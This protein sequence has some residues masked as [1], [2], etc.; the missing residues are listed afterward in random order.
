MANKLYEEE[1]IRGIAEAIRTKN[2]T[3]NTYT[4]AQMADAILN[5][6]DLGDGIVPTGSIEI[7]SNGAHDVTNFASAIVNVETSDGDSLP[8]NVK[9]GVL[10]LESDSTTAITITHGCDTIPKN[11]VCVPLDTIVGKG[12]VGG[13]SIEGVTGTISSVEDG[14]KSFST[15]VAFIQN[16]TETTFDI[17]PRSDAYPLIGGHNYLWV[18]IS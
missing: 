17:V 13:F 14:T 7:T 4:V 1:N 11:I 9:T 2:G 18:A 5:L 8:S 15:V 12:S 6:R 16:I 10:A 3:D